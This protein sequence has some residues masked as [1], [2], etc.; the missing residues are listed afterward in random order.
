MT[1]RENELFKTYCPHK[2]PRKM[3][4]EIEAL[5]ES[6]NADDSTEAVLMLLDSAFSEDDFRDEVAA[7]IVSVCFR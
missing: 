6:G 2:T 5:L 1:K 7:A 4:D 3:R